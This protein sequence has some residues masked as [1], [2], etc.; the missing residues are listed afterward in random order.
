VVVATD[1]GETRELPCDSIVMAVGST[2]VPHDDIAALCAAR[3]IP[4]TIV[5]DAKKAR[6]AIDATREAA[7][8]ALSI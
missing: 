1:G 3:N 2:S 5:G 7:L 6:R 4:Y 8:A